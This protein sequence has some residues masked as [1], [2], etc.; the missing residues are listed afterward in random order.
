MVLNLTIGYFQETKSHFMDHF[1]L[2][3]PSGVA[4]VAVWIYITK[5]TNRNLPLGCILKDELPLSSELK[6]FCSLFRWKSK[7]V[8]GDPAHQRGRRWFSGITACCHTYRVSTATAYDHPDDTW[9]KFGHQ[10]SER[11]HV[12]FVFFSLQIK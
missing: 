12:R 3:L 1:W 7:D 4:T 10:K 9:E 5:T 11:P 2:V 6:S 8:A